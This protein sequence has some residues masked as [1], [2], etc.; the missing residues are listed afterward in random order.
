VLVAE[1][2]E[3]ASWIISFSAG[4]TPEDVAELLRACVKPVT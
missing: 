1:D 4:A 3:L 2:P